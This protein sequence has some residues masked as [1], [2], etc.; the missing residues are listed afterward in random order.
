MRKKKKMDSDPTPQHAAGS[1]LRRGCRLLKRFSLTLVS[2]LL[3]LIA[4]EAVLRVGLL[5]QATSEHPVWIPPRLRAK[6][7]KIDRANS[8]FARQNPYRFTDKVRSYTRPRGMKRLAVLG[9]SFIWGDGIPWTETWSH[10]LERLFDSDPD[11]NVEVIHWG[12]NGW[13]TADELDFLIEEGGKYELD[14]LII[15]WASNDP[16]VGRIKRGDLKW[17]NAPCWTPV[18]RVLPYTFAFVSSGINNIVS[19]HSDKYGYDNW[20]NH[21][22]SKENLKH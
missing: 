18:K 1:V 11:Y 13:S 22:Y 15:G 5:D 6:D 20:L 12:R 4:L 16:D 14:G 3:C 19:A 2:L 9:D 21:L 10:K 7:R 8:Q 17:Q